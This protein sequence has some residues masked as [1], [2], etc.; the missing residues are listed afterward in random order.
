M[1][2][3]ASDIGDILSAVPHLQRGPGGTAAVL[4]DGK[5]I[6]QRAWGYADLDRRIPMTPRTLMPICSIS[7]QMVCLVMISLLRNPT[8]TMLERKM[9]SRKQLDEELRR[10]LPLLFNQKDG[11][12]LTVDHLCHMQSGIRDYWAMLV[13]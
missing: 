5:V 13:D 12:E 6:G 7:K 4:K 10:L 2:D 8:P 3:S 1:A 11:E 9:D